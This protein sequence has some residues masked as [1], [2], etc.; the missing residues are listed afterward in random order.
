MTEAIE[1]RSGGFRLR[2]RLTP[3]SS[4]DGVDGPGADAR[5]AVFLKAR[6][7]AA[8]EK[9]AANAA[10]EVVLAK[11][12]GVPKTAVR[13]EKGAT[14]RLKIVAIEGDAEALKRAQALLKQALLGQERG[15]K[16]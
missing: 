1:P 13:V 11:A 7:R 16:T 15:S 8:P 3:K 4:A 12:L 10:L 6:V 5:G 14:G 2:V 9:G